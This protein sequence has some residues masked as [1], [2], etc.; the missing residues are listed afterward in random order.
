MCLVQDNLSPSIA[1]K[2]TW[3]AVYCRTSNPAIHFPGAGVTRE[4]MKVY[5]REML[6]GPVSS[7]RHAMWPSH[8]SRHVVLSIRSLSCRMSS[9]LEPPRRP[10]HLEDIVAATR[11]C[12]EWTDLPSY[13]LSGARSHVLQFVFRFVIFVR[14][15]LACS[16]RK[17]Q[18]RLWTRITV[19]LINVAAAVFWS[20]EDFAFARRRYSNP[21]RNPRLVMVTI[22]SNLVNLTASPLLV[23][24]YSVSVY[25]I[26]Q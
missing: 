12:V 23:S 1:D 19:P 25:Q 15:A 26:S 10:P 11:D 18:L 2:S 3:I 21:S 24:Q 7:G 16:F 6:K 17:A 5:R 4:N 22:S 8:A 13:R 14:A 20:C 9:D